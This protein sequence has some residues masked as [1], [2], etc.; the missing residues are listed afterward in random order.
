MKRKAQLFLLH[1]AGGN[2]YSFN[3]IT[4]GLKNLE[5]IPL[6]LP[7]RGRRMQEG[8]LKDFD[9]AANDFFHQIVPVLSGAPFLIYGHSMGAYLGLRVANL[10]ESAG[11]PPAYLIVSGNPGPGVPRERPVQMHLLPKA[12]FIQELRILG[13]VPEELF[14]DVDL[15]AFFE[16]ILRADFEVAEASGLEQEP[17]IAAPLYALMGS[18]EE[19]VDQIANWGRFTRSEFRSEILEGNHFFIHKHPQRMADILKGC[20]ERVERQGV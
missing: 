17:P 18:E 10:L 7:G 8:L 12:E 1:F 16:P 6:E 20:Y 3:T 4:P 5:V 11:R 15:F 14:R 19:N 2:I 13:G 9:L